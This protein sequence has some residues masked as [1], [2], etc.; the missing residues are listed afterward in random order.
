M[1]RAHTRKKIQTSR[2]NPTPRRSSEA[3]P[4]C[5]LL[6]FRVIVE[7][8]IHKFIASLSASDVKWQLSQIAPMVDPLHDPTRKIMTMRDR[9]LE[10]SSS[11]P[12]FL[13]RLATSARRPSNN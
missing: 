9:R 3:L 8:A 10:C 2:G 13:P 5:H 11:T 1:P 12:N 6:G 7:P 4:C